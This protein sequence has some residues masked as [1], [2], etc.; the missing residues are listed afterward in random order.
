ML[1]KFFT[2]PKDR[3][4]FAIALVVI[5]LAGILIGY[6]TFYQ[7]QSGFDQMST[8]VTQN[9]KIDTLQVE[10]MTY[11]AAEPVAEVTDV[12]PTKS[13]II[14]IAPIKTKLAADTLTGKNEDIDETIN[15]DLRD[16]NSNVTDSDDLGFTESTKDLLDSVISEEN[17]SLNDDEPIIVDEVDTQTEIIDDTPP[18]AEPAIVAEPIEKNEITTRNPSP[19][20]KCIVVIGAYSNQTNV[21]KLIGRLDQEGYPVFKVP[22][23]GLTRV[24][25]YIDCAYSTSLLEKIRREYGSDA[26]LMKAK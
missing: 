5:A 24:G 6:F 11:V 15:E 26:F 22:F 4:D 19:K 20:R 2:N 13:K 17:E 21:R 9:T 25:A 3:E 14:P 12:S 8:L 18:I 16:E 1:S 7:G 10:G 23:G